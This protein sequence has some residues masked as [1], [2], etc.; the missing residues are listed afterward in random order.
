MPNSQS[1]TANPE[2]PQSFDD[3]HKS[4]VG[5]VSD[6]E[7]LPELAS[8]SSVKLIELTVSDT[9]ADQRKQLVGR[10]L[11]FHHLTFWVSNAKQAALHFCVH[12]GFEPYAYA[13]L[14]TGS[15]DVASHVVRQNQILVQFSSPLTDRVKEISD[16]IARHGDGV[17]D[18]AF[19]VDDAASILERARVR[20]ATVVREL[21]T[22]TDG[23]G[24]MRIATVR[25][26]GDTCHTFI[27]KSNY[28][29]VFMPNYRMASEAAL[30]LLR[31]LPNVKL[32]FID[33]CVAAQQDDQMKNVSDWYLETLLMNRFWSVDDINI[34]TDFSSLR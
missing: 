23:Q 25:A 10:C 27:E 1:S 4:S 3:V 19:E 20:G 14:E 22:L 32:D 28:A 29:G 9:M 7:S 8:Q 30:P 12:F 15:R 24:E 5:S 16:H 31:S 33:H 34:V 21:C 13:G 11:N 6:A 2:A 18:V 17:Q 26:F